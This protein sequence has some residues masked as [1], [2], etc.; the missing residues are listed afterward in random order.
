MNKEIEV[1]Y[2]IFELELAPPFK[3]WKGPDQ[4]IYNK[5]SN[6]VGWYSSKCFYVEY[7]KSVA[8]LKKIKQVFSADKLSKED[9]YNI[10]KQLFNWLKGKFPDKIEFVMI[11]NMSVYDEVYYRKLRM[12]EF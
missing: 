6:V 9:V 10:A 2:K 8:I 4:D 1:L 3:W 5:H 11:Y 7:E 12:Y